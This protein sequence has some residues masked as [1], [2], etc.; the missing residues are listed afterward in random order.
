MTRVVEVGVAVVVEV[1][2]AVVVEA[3]LSLAPIN[4]TDSYISPA[5]ATLI[6]SRVD[7]GG[8]GGGGAET[9]IFDR[10][11]IIL[12]Q[13]TFSHASLRIFWP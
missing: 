7:G 5:P 13:N 11:D 6:D 10:T 12:F 9:E 4:R 1:G 2:V 8:G 3:L